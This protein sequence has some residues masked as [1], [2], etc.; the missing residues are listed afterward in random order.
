VT[1][2]I[3]PEVRRVDH[4]GEEIEVDDALRDGLRIVEDLS[5]MQVAVRAVWAVPGEPRLRLAIIERPATESGYGPQLIAFSEGD[6]LRVLHEGPR[7]YDDDFVEPTFFRFFD[8]TLLLADHG[9]EDA[10]GILAWSVEAGRIRDLGQIHIA[11]PEDQD[12]FTRGAAAVAR[13]EMRHGKY[14]VTIPGPVLLNPQGTDER[15]IAERGQTATLV[16]SG[17]RFVLV[18][19]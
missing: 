16:E 18:E 15:V 14:T 19:R 17:G 8:R 6:E 9:S 11:L 1:T 3:Q 5:R 12:V 2:G 4:N 10:Y 13:V 7:L